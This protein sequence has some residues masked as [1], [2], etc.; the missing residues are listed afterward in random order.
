MSRIVRIEIHHLPLF[1]TETWALAWQT[2]DRGRARIV[3]IVRL[4][5]EDG[6]E[7]ISGSLLGKGKGGLC[8]EQVSSWLL[9]AESGD[10]ERQRAIL[11]EMALEGS[12]AWWL[13]GAL[14]DLRGKREGKPLYQILAGGGES[15]ACVEGV[16]G[17]ACLPSFV[18]VE[19]AL[20]WC[21]GRRAEGWQAF[22]LPLRLAP[23]SDE[24]FVQAIRA[25]LGEEV[26]L[27]LQGDRWSKARLSTPHAPGQMLSEALDFVARLE[28]YKIEWVEDILDLYAYDDLAVL[29]SESAI[30]IA[31]GEKYLGW[32]EFKIPFEKG[33]LD[34]Y[35][36]DPSRIGLTS[37]AQVLDACL[38]RDL[39]FAPSSGFDPFARL[40]AAHLYAAWPH[41]FF[42]PCVWASA[43]FPP[44]LRDLGF[45]DALQLRSDG[46]LRLPQSPGLGV[47]LNPTILQ[48]YA[49]RVFADAIR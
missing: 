35:Q 1:L 33:S 14:W 27:M 4:W 24:G 20:K 47:V 7:G 42:L 25:A 34:L 13:E 22:R 21:E 10:I 46:T 38:R 12:A 28:P 15:E 37:A 44:L 5:T 43:L 2:W 9:G 49:R 29:R 11:Q 23:E 45:A 18:E 17:L 26:P 6:V 30:P 36:P 41:K 16:P 39:H 31:G 48:T 40:C 3:E 8:G 32:H 19:E